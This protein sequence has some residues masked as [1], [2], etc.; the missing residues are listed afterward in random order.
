MSETTNIILITGA[1]SNVGT[2]FI[3]RNIDQYTTIIA[4][5]RTM[6]PTL[7]KLSQNHPNRIIL[8]QC[9]FA[10]LEATQQFADSIITDGII[11]THFLHLP[12]IPFASVKYAKTNWTM[13][14]DE[15]SV[16]LRSAMILSQVLLSKMAKSKYGKIVFMLTSFVTNQPATKYAVPYTTSKYALLGLMKCLASEYADKHICINAVSPALMETAFL[17]NT[18]QLVVDLN[19]QASPIKRNLQT[20]DVLPSIE[21]LLSRESDCITGQNLP[22]TGGI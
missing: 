3:S 4:Q 10:D 19:A 14:E 7:T 22:I 8:K 17:E 9:D 2:D 5:Y 11:P 12:S 21:F 15:L 16:S 13:F 6:N 1:S 18:P 20:I